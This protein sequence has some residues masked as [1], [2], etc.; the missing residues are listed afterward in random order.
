MTVALAAPTTPEDVLSEAR[1]LDPR[2]GATTE[3]LDTL[4]HKLPA[5]GRWPALYQHRLTEAALHPSERQLLL[6]ALEEHH[7]PQ[8]CA[9]DAALPLSAQIDRVRLCSSSPEALGD[10]L[11]TFALSRMGALPEDPDLFELA[12]RAAIAIAPHSDMPAGLQDLA[13]VLHPLVQER[14]AAQWLEP[15]AIT[16]PPSLATPAH[17]DAQREQIATILQAQWARH[18][19]RLLEVMQTEQGSHL[20]TLLNTSERALASDWSR[21]SDPAL[22]QVGRALLQAIGPPPE[23]AGELPHAPPGQWPGAV[24]VPPAEPPEAAWMRGR[25]R[26]RFAARHL[27]LGLLLAGLSLFA[28]V[29]LTKAR[30]V[31]AAG[32]G[33]GLLLTV[34]GSLRAAGVTPLAQTRTLFS[35]TDWQLTVLHPAGEGQHETEGGWIRQQTIL[36]APAAFRAVTLG[37]SSAH[38]S[39]HLAEESF[40]AIVEH[41]L[42]QRWPDE[43]VEVLNLGVGGTTSNGVLHVGQ[44]ALQLGADVLLIYYGHNEVAQFTQLSM[45]QDTRPRQLAWRV[46]LSHSRL[47]SVLARL[48]QP[49]QHA[50]VLVV[51]AGLAETAP[52][53]VEIDALKSI[54][55]ENFRYNLGQLIADAQSV[56]CDVILMNVATNYRFIDLQPFPSEAAPSPALDA[57]AAALGQGDAEAALSLARGVLDTVPPGSPNHMEAARLT[58]GLMSDAG[59]GLGA[60]AVLQAAIDASARP[61]VVTSGIRAATQELATQHGVRLLDV[62][63]L[64]YARSPDGLS[65]PGMFWDDLHPTRLGHQLI[66]DALYPE[67]SALAEARIEP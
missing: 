31:A 47:Y 26:P 61:G 21:A 57:A 44:A 17:S 13:E 6:R 64:F 37:A 62:E 65:A 9:P 43:P 11:R 22:A 2:R 4:I 5:S 19:V 20:E 63:R 7:P 15:L 40:S 23:D 51:G 12:L 35:F 24:A 53:P 8:R 66:A 41:R 30:P 39:N 58:A 46:R 3:K 10:L 36:D 16:L 18:G 60:R 28:G 38:A 54:A 29:R 42:R 59:D 56:G 32:F 55:V 52:G 14:V 34:E 1:N 50:L 33:L 49:K 45:I 67:V 48:L 25:P 27:L